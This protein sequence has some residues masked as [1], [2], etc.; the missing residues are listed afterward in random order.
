MKRPT[1]LEGAFLALIA[2][3]AGTAVYSAL[4]WILPAQSA[5]RLV[6]TG[7]G[8]AYLIYLLGRST[9]RVGRV[10][11]T[12]LWLAVSGLL[13]LLSPTLSFFL[14]AH[15]AMGWAVRSL[16]FHQGLLAAL[17][18]LGLGVLAL[19]ASLGAYLHTGSLFLSLWCLFLVQSLFVFIPSRLPA[20]T[21]IHESEEDS[22]RRAHQTAEAA[23]QRLSSMHQPII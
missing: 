13:W 15:L 4:D 23:V 9:E 5:L 10:T 2:A 12:S 17:A 3:V 20:G 16:Y 1:F 7:L 18:D 14:A 11:V 8:A 19:T 22:F 21:D 6:A